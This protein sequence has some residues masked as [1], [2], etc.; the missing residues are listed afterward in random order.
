MQIIKLKV[1]GNMY[2]VNVDPRWTLLD[3]L[4]EKLELTGTKKGC[5]GGAC[6]ACTVIIS[7]NGA[8]PS[9]LMLA[10]ECEGKDIITI[11]GLGKGGELHPLQQAFAENFAFECGFCTSGMIM[12][13]KSL[14][15]ENPSP[16]EEDIK[17]GLNGNICRCGAYQEII[18]A[19]LV[20]SKI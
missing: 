7:G 20:A 8:V 6:G 18:Q 1:N 2:E 10:V 16:A 4:R 13:A 11:E 14:L 12:T 3:V 17:E 9:C 19:V 15:D 5:N